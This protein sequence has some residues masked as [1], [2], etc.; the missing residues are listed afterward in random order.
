MRS[1]YLNKD[2]EY[3]EILENIC[4]LKN[5]K[6][7]YEFGILDGYSID[8]FAKAAPNAFIY[9]FDIFDDFNGNK[10]TGDIYK[11]FEENN[12]IK[13][14]YGDFYKKWDGMEDEVD[15]IHIDIANTADVYKFA[16]EK[17]LPKLS[18]D[19]ILILEGG[20]EQR[21]EV[22][23]MNKYNKPKINPY[24]QQLKKRLDLDIKTVGEFPSL[25]IIKRNPTFSLRLLERDDIFDGYFELIN[26]FT[27]DLHI[28]EM[29]VMGYFNELQNQFFKTFVIKYNGQV[30]ATAKIV[31]ERKAHNNCR[32]MGNIQDFVIHPDYRN[33]GLGRLLMEKLVEVGKEEDCY[34]IILSCN[35]DVKGFYEKMDFIRKGN[36]MCIYL[37]K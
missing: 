20:S 4:F 7:I 8:R 23:W 30:I 17:Y 2:L 29:D 31:L 25:T 12:K 34:K 33:N 37:Q 24:L 10:P 15:I 21:D 3:G 35:D 22:E 26:H 28:T 9:A 1:S 18:K 36:E 11:R 27:R 16:I 6:V 14:A 13:I 5:P 19:G 32:K